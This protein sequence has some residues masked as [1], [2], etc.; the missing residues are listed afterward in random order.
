MADSR[1]YGRTHQMISKSLDISAKRH[2]LISSNIANM[3][4]IGYTPSDLD[5]RVPLNGPWR[6]LN[7][8]IWTKPMKD[9]CPTITAGP[10]MKCGGKR[11][12]MWISITWIL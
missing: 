1:I 10:P 11:V 12:R 7:L 6:G 8:I 4:T 2:N 5:F 9:T 3:D